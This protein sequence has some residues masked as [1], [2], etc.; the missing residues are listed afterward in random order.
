VT[1]LP[2]GIVIHD[3]RR[4]VRTHLSE[5]GVPSNVAELC[6]N[7]RPTGVKRVYDVAEL[8]DQR[9]AALQKWESYLQTLMLD[10]DADTHAPKI[11]EQ[12]GEVLQQVQADPALRRYLLSTL[13]EQA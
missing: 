4:T 11:P 7:H 5:L 1:G 8:I 3:L 6:L 10:G 2:Q 9:Y 12:F 13:L